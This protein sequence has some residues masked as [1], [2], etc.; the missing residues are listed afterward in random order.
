MYRQNGLSLV[1]L[2]IAITLGLI[3]MTGVIQ[4]FIS[5]R[6]SFQAQQSTSVIQESGRLAAELINRDLRMAG[7]T[8][9]RGRMS[10]INN[11]LTPVTYK[12]DF[13]NGISVYDAKDVADLTPLANTRALV[14]RGVLDSGGAE[15]TK[16]SEL[17]KLTTALIS[18]EVGACADKSNRINGICVGDTL[19]VADYQKTIVFK[20][21]T[22][23]AT[24]SSVDIG[25]AGTWGKPGPDY[26]NYFMPGAR[27]SVARTVTY[28][29]REGASKRPSLYQK[30]N[31]G[32][33]VELLEGVSNIAVR[34]N[35]FGSTSSYSDATGKMNG[36]W[37]NKNDPVVSVQLELLIEGLADNVL[38]E[39]QVYEFDGKTVTATDRRLRNVFSTT[40]ALRNQLP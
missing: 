26:E 38:E 30:I 16:R 34:F 24:G 15:L 25:F 22:I 27:V 9:F 19:M 23:A 40:I 29:I 33:A 28:F 20:A 1:E 39:K 3:L 13:L 2:M 11:K 32:D 37:N 31:D 10:A 35:R 36:L 21:T 4:L 7:F 6:E 14:I 18:T 5:S 8:G 17:N 12:N